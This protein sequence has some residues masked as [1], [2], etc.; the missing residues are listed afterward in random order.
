M[1][2]YNVNLI[3][4]KT[5]QVTLTLAAHSKDEAVKYALKGSYISA[6]NDTETGWNATLASVKECATNDIPFEAA[7]AESGYVVVVS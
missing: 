3:F 7:K 4:T 2:T 6:C 1:K 5:K